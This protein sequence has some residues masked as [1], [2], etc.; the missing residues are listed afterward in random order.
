MSVPKVV[1][2]GRP[3]VGKSSLFNW[4][5]GRRVSIVDPKDGVTRDRVGH[6][7]EHD[8]SYFE[9]FDT[10]GMGL[11]DKDGL[12]SQI[13][14]QIDAAIS[15]AAL[16]LFVVD[17][18]SGLV[19][20]DELVAR[21]LRYSEKPIVC[22]ANKCDNARYE[23]QAAAEF[24]KF[25]RK[26]VQVSVTAGRHRDELLDEIVQRLP[27]MAGAAPDAEMK[28]AVV[29]KRNVGKS[30]LINCLAGVE[31]M[32]VSEV[33]GTTRDSVDVRFEHN[34]RV[35]VA[36]DTAGV[37]RKRSLADSIE[38][39]GFTRVQQTIGRADVVLFFLDATS[40][41]S[42]VDKQL[43]HFI[44]QQHKPCIFVVNKWDLMNATPTGKFDH[45]LTDTF[46]AWTYVPRVFITATTG[47]NVQGLIDLAQNLF[48]QA[49]TR[50]STPDLNRVIREAVQRRPPPVAEGQ[51][52]KI[53][54]ATQ[55]AAAP[56][57]IVFFCNRPSLFDATYQRYLIGYCRDHLP[58]AEV[59]IKLYLRR[60]DSHRSLEESGQ[61]PMSQV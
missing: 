51:T 9:L 61:T 41:I 26:L 1:I 10:G 18:Q 36:I 43:A 44:S 28:L 29:G 22:V 15:E 16:L 34:G 50:V 14:R 56:P 46:P 11:S 48:K 24:Y 31:R 35:F 4:L 59:P 33:P 27:P 60:R 38:F 40:R 55:V 19:A 49:N 57:T 30:T 7:V 58:Y 12:T 42:K 25:G 6:L 45:Y 53:Y 17:A 52:P 47:K 13:E 54:Y 5:I 8:G 39:Y 23:A 32:I 2:V 3:N 37:R 21:R 20:L